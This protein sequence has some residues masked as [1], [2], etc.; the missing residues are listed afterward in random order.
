ML[1]GGLVGVLTADYGYETGLDIANQAGVF[2]KKGINR[3]GVASRTRSLLD[4]AEQEVKLTALGAFVAPSINGVRNI[5]RSLAFGAG[6]Q[7]LK[8]AEKGMVGITDV[9][10]YRSV[11]G[12]P[13]VG[14]RFPLIGGGISKN[15]AQRAEKMNVILNNMNNRI[16]PSVSYNRLSEAVGAASKVSAGKISGELTKLRKE[17]FSHAI[18]RGANVKLAG[19]LGDSSPHSIITEFTAHMA[20][21]TAKGIDGTPLPVV[22]RNKLNTFFDNVLQ[23]PGS[24]TLARADAML[25]ELGFIMKQGGMKTNATAIN[26][27][28]IRVIKKYVIWLSSTVRHTRNK[29]CG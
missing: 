3:P 16:A 10:S 25:D 21:T 7:E 5:T 1:A 11:Q 2:G 17:W 26:F 8:I 4:T 28:T 22:V 24:V 23:E 18:S 13:N 15:L 20:Q 27:A 9:S 14:G 29:V 12:F 6:P 19:N